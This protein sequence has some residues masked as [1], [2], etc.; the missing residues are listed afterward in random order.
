MRFSCFVAGRKGGRG[1][2]GKGFLAATCW[3]CFG[4]NPFRICGCGRG[5]FGFVNGFWVAAWSRASYE[6]CLHQPSPTA[7]TLLIR[8]SDKALICMQC[9][10]VCIS[11]V[12]FDASGLGWRLF[13]FLAK[14]TA[15]VATWCVVLVGFLLLLLGATVE[16]STCFACALLAQVGRWLRTCWYNRLSKVQFRCYFFRFS[17][18][19][20]GCM[21]WLGCGTSRLRWQAVVRHDVFFPDKGPIGVL[22]E[23]IQTK[24][25]FAF[26]SSVAGRAGAPA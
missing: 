9:G 4:A 1:Y 26:S 7:A 25:M 12:P 14:S 3:C 13:P 24:C 22:A 5:G 10:R 21:A 2:R 18:L 17:K 19:R 15:V 16:W 20:K 23:R 6:S 8:R 11:L